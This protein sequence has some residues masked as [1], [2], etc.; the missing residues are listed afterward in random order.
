MKK[1]ISFHDIDRG[2]Q[3]TNQEQGAG[4]FMNIFFFYSIKNLK[5]EKNNVHQRKKKAKWKI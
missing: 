2:L 3:Y 5:Q 1:I 4:N